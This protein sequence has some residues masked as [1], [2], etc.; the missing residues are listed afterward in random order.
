M[1]KYAPTLA[2][3]FVTTCDETLGTDKRVRVEEVGALQFG[4][5]A[6]AK[7]IVAVKEGL[8]DLSKEPLWKTHFVRKSRTP[9]E[10]V[11]DTASDRF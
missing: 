9:Q 7:K 10:N 6:R 8:N 3:L 2:Y 1:H 11:T 4:P 5:N